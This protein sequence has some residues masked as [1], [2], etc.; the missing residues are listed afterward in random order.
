MKVSVDTA[1]GRMV[2]QG[3]IGVFAGTAFDPNK[4]CRL[5]R[6]E[7]EIREVLEAIWRSPDKAE[8]I[9]ARIAAKNQQLYEFERM[10]EKR[11]NP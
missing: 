6:D 1:E 11:T 5:A 8:E 2:K 7:M 9:L 10:L 4:K 3:V